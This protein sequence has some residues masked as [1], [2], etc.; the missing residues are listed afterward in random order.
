MLVVSLATVSVA[1]TKNSPARGKA[2]TTVPAGRAPVV[3]PQ[4]LQAEQALAK[5]DYATAE[6]LLLALTRENPQDFRSWYDLGYVYAQTNRVEQAIAAFKKSIALDHSIAQTQSA[7]GT[8]LLSLDR[9]AEAVPYLRRAT[10]LQPTFAAWMALGNAQEKASPA[11]AIAAYGKAATLDAGSPAPHLRAGIVHE[12][13]Q[14]WADAEREYLAAQKIRPSSEALA[15]LVNVYRATDRSDD[16]ENAL[17][18]YL[19]VAPTDGPG[20]LLL[21][22]LLAARGQK[23]EAAREFAAAA[24]AS[25]DP[26]TLKA[27]ASELAAEKQHAPALSLYRRLLELTPDDADAHYR[28]GAVLSSSGNF[29][30]AEQHFLHALKLDS[31][32]TDA[33][34]S[35]AVAASKNDHHELA[36]RALD[37]R[38]KLAPE[39]AATYFLRATSYDHLKQYP[40]AAENYRQFLQVANGSS[41]DQE[42]QARHRLIAIQPEGGNK[43]K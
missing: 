10:E 8:L 5:R 15:G 33:Y 43:K 20:H 31:K 11:E 29:A 22:R 19:E 35:L 42:W 7:L 34:G 30:E 14:H 39:T 40:L 36:V 23:E 21:G 25:S 18:R 17:R 9:H 4:L 13:L 3:P 2:R 27:L 6:P 12:R 24:Q 16:A 37:A 38:A 32:L 1:Q 41:P 26:A 28:I